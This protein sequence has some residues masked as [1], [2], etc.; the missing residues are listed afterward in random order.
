MKKLSLYIFLVLMW[1]NAGF[2]EWK[3]ISMS[4]D[5]NTKTFMDYDTIIR[6]GDTVFFLMLTSYQ[7]GI[8][9][10]GYPTAYSDI[11][12]QEG[13]CKTNEVAVLSTKYF[14]KQMGKGNIII[15]HFPEP[16]EWHYFSPE[17]VLGIV[18]KYACK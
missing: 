11:S 12:R 4:T 16:I 14:D 1:C 15:T 17:S 10:E 18:L 2:A 5:G 9:A 3:V 7:D 6:Q 13:N 8:D